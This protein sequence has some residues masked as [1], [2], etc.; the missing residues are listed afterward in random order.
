MARTTVSG[1]VNLG[2]TRGN[3]GETAAGFAVTPIVSDDVAV[4]LGLSKRGLDANWQLMPAGAF[5]QES[6]T[7][8]WKLFTELTWTVNVCEP[9]TFIVAEVGETVPEKLPEDPDPFG[10]SKATAMEDQSSTWPP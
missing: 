1:K 10:A 2:R 3:D 5:G 7:C 8:P 4:A 9:P 6:D